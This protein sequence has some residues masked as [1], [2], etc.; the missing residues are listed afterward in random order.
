MGIDNILEIS[1][2]LVI[3]NIWVLN[4]CTN[5][6]LVNWTVAMTENTNVT[7]S[8]STR[9]TS[10]YKTQSPSKTFSSAV[11]RRSG[12]YLVTHL[13][14]HSKDVEFIMRAME[15]SEEKKWYQT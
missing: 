8:N 13:V 15:I 10:P 12:H 11:Q 9:L 3:S 2:I 6:P 14:M 4:S 7:Q 5:I 1:N